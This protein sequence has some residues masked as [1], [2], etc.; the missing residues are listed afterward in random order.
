MKAHMLIKRCMDARK[1]FRAR[2]EELRGITKL[3]EANIASI[4]SA[5]REDLPEQYAREL[6]AKD[7]EF[8]SFFNPRYP[9]LLKEIFLPPL[10]IYI[11]GELPADDVCFSIIGSRRCSEYGLT[12]AYKISCGLARNGVVIVSGLARGIDSMAHKGAIE[13]GGKTI[14]VLGCGVDVCYPPENRALMEK[15]INGNGC[16]ISE[17]PPGVSPMP[18]HFPV[19]NRVISGLSQGTLVVEAADKS[20][21]IITADHALE[22][23]RTVFAVPGNITSKLSDGTNALIKQGATPVTCYEDVLYELGIDE[24]EDNPVNSTE[25]AASLFEEERIV[26]NYVGQESVTM[27]YLLNKLNSDPPALN[28]I[29][30]LLE[31]KGLIKRLPGQRYIRI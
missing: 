17:Y 18:G 9:A 14:A 20:G 13:G 6:E 19:R 8:V 22:Q 15:I 27:E 11:R 24:T 21:T 10:G 30:T 16:V 12:A 4:A 3:T 7:I 5:Q 2:R 25:N 1:I 29:L 31:L 28:Y 23:G 26:Y